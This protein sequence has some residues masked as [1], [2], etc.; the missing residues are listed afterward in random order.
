MS[1]QIKTTLFLKKLFVDN[2]RSTRKHDLKVVDILIIH[3]DLLSKILR[4]WFWMGVGFRMPYF[5]VHI[6]GIIGTCEFRPYNE[7]KYMLLL[8]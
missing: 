6:A 4:H 8:P 5:S 7:S 2:P 1:V 3:M